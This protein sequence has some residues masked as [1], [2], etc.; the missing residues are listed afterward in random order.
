MII[1]VLFNFQVL[2]SAF[3][4]CITYP[5]EILFAGLGRAFRAFFTEIPSPWQPV[6][7]VIIVIFLL[8]TLVM[9]FGY[10]I[11]LPML[12]KIEPKT[13][14]YLHVEKKIK[15]NEVEKE[16]QKLFMSIEASQDTEECSSQETQ[17]TQDSEYTQKS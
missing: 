10:R 16:K 17:Y 9:L 1:N 7:L 14:V 12:L 4:H 6:M 3:S 15:P 5:V 11:H 13:P 8:L 2:S